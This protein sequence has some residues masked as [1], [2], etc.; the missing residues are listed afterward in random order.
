M[1]NLICFIR[2]FFVLQKSVLNEIK[3]LYKKWYIWTNNIEKTTVIKRNTY[4]KK[5]IMV[6]MHKK[7]K[8]V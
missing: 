6:K 4:N 2:Q 5:R 3:Y 7:S 8:K 1:L